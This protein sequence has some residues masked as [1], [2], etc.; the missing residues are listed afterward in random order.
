MHSLQD[1]K[2]YLGLRSRL[3]QVWINRWTVLI[4]LVLARVLIAIGSLHDD[5]DNA[6][7]QAL[8]ACSTVESLGSNVASLPHYMATGVNSLAAHGVENAVNGLETVLFDIVTAAEE[9]FVFWVNMYIGLYE[10]LIT[11]AVTGSLHAVLNG[12]DEIIKFVN[13]SMSS[14][15]GDINGAVSDFTTALQKFENAINSVES[16]LTGNQKA[17]DT[18]NLKP[19]LDKM[20]SLSIPHT[21]TDEITKLNSSIP[22]FDEV[23]NTT[24][25]LLRMPFEEVK[26]LMKNKLGNYSFDQSVFPIPE[27]EQL[28]FCNDNDGINSFFDGLYDLCDTARK[29]FIVV[30]LLAAIAACVPMAIMEIRRWRSQQTY[31]SRMQ[32]YAVDNIDR[33]YIAS[34]PW[35]SF[36]GIK[37]SQKFRSP[38]M[39]LLARWF[40]AYITS[41]PAIVLL[42]IALAGLFSSLCQY[43]I[44]KAVEKEVPELAGDIGEFADK[45]VGALN[46]ASARWANGTNA[47]INATNNDINK[48][49]FGW[50]NTSTHAVNNTLNTFVDDMITALNKTFGGTPLYEPI[51]DVYT[52]LIGL[53]V[54]AVQQ[55]L[56]WVSDHAYIEFPMFPNDTFSAGAQAAISTNKTTAN[57]QNN[58]FLSDPG[59]D[60]TDKVTQAVTNLADKVANGIRTE[61]LLSTA[62]LSLYLLVV[63]MGLARVIYSYMRSPK[64]RAEGGATY[65]GDVAPG[66]VEDNTGA[67]TTRSVRSSARHSGMETNEIA[68]STQQIPQAQQSTMTDSA[69]PAYERR[70]PA[71]H[72]KFPGSTDVHED[73]YQN[74]KLGVTMTG[75]TPHARTTNNPFLNEKNDMF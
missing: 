71:F 54:Q 35:T 36:T 46:N 9:I 57:G 52:C 14:I 23:K 44:L 20:T 25:A 72:T 21:V 56:T 37:I 51:L 32:L 7:S 58:S 13:S 47:V 27:R 62:I 30:L 3:S 29:I 53:K 26:T 69:P 75:E 34:R 61:A 59:D 28:T 66:M 11:F 22:S 49:V 73:E 60:A 12:A 18:L 8:A 38:K 10:C 67:V 45:V 39:Q 19:E 4:F 50:V 6:K 68:N 40:V 31:A 15:S 1:V 43:T 64:T 63:I 41:V 17:P 74:E 65:A 5:I 24:N 55:G 16:V 70:F 48:E 33:V 42:S 2:P